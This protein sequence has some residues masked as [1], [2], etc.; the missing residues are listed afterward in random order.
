MVIGVCPARPGASTVMASLSMPPRR[1]II[2]SV[3]VVVTEGQIGAM[4]VPPEIAKTSM[5]L[6]GLCPVKRII[7]A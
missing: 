2:V 6:L 7:Q 3:T 5:G 4:L 1:R